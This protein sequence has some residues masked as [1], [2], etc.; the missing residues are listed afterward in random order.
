M[1]QWFVPQYTCQHTALP[2]QQGPPAHIVDTF[3]AARR[4]Q[5]TAAEQFQNA[6]VIAVN[7]MLVMDAE[8]QRLASLNARLAADHKAVCDQRVSA[9]AE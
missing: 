6:Q 7:Q 8:M 4:A 9:A 5:A 3:M 1:G 2:M